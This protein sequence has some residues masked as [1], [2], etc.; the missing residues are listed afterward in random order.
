MTLVVNGS[1]VVNIKYLFQ[2]IT[3][4]LLLIVEKKDKKKEIF[5][6]LHKKVS[7]LITCLDLLISCYFVIEL[8]NINTNKVN[9]L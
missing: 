1:C 2:I 8:C 9:V 6:V 7:C 5:F 4:H 3:S